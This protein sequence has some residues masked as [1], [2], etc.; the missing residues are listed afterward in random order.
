M[1]YICRWSISRLCPSWKPSTVSTSIKCLRNISWSIHC[2]K[3]KTWIGVILQVAVFKMND[4]NK[5]AYSKN[6]R[7]I[8]APILGW[9]WRVD[10]LEKGY[11][12][13][14]NFAQWFK[15]YHKEI[16]KWR[17][18]LWLATYNYVKIANNGTY[19]DPLRMYKHSSQVVYNKGKSGLNKSPEGE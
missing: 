19:I 8:G 14:S 16:I 2:V 10:I 3:I 18:W 13:N 17:I 9:M 7:D 12:D 11:L 1:L 5:C 4:D 6:I 15:Q